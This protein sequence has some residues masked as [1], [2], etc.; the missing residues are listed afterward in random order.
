MQIVEFA[1]DRQKNKT[2]DIWHVSV[3]VV[4]FSSDI[5]VSFS[6]GISTLFF[7]VKN[8]MWTDI[9]A[10]R[11]AIFFSDLYLSCDYSLQMKLPF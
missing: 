8:L 5:I 4:F 9:H 1:L 7:S 3:E 10:S 2:G 6:F 11:I